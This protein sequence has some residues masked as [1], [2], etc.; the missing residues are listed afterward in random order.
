MHGFL[1]LDIQQLLAR[2][3]IANMAPYVFLGSEILYQAHTILFKP[4][5]AADTAWHSQPNEPSHVYVDLYLLR[6]FP[7]TVGPLCD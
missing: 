4:T 5:G 3:H 1:V 7:C 6:S 2:N